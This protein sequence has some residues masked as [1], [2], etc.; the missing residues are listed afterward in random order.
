MI[1]CECM[2][3]VTGGLQGLSEESSPFLGSV[4]SI[5]LSFSLSEAAPVC[6]NLKRDESEPTKKLPPLVCR[7]DVTQV[8]PIYS[9]HYVELLRACM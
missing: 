5:E 9:V 1:K 8:L 6:Q 3:I 4:M 7:P 2:T